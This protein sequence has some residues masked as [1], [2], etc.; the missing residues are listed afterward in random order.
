MDAKNEEVFP[1]RPLGFELLSGAEPGPD[2]PGG[3][4]LR[5]RLGG[6]PRRL[7]QP[8]IFDLL[9]D[10][11]PQQRRQA[12]GAAAAGLAGLPLLEAAMQRR[13]ARAPLGTT[14]PVIPRA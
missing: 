5:R 12:L 10:L 3:R 13:A 6:L 11:P 14:P 9:Q 2:P 1:G 7:C 4:R 8:L